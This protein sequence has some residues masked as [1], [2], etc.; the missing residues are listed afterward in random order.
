MMEKNVLEFLMEILDLKSCA[1]NIL[2]SIPIEKYHPRSCSSFESN[3]FIL[4]YRRYIIVLY[5]IFILLILIAKLSV[6]ICLLHLL[7][8][9][10]LFSL[11]QKSLQN[12][13]SL[14]VINTSQLR[15]AEYLISLLDLLVVFL[16]YFF[17][18]FIFIFV[19]MKFS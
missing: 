15:I 19:W 2:I 12:L 11:L 8:V 3:E 9:S 18:I 10:L 6:S 7:L 13:K 5:W 14:L 16:S 4:C 17:L 1:L